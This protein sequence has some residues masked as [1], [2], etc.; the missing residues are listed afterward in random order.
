[1][2][3]NGDH[4]NITMTCGGPEDQKVHHILCV[5]ERDQREFV[6]ELRGRKDSRGLRASSFI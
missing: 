5:G 2:E 3:G 1:M 4:L 6:T